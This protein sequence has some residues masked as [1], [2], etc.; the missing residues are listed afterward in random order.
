MAG[1]LLR[2]V[3]SAYEVGLGFGVLFLPYDVATVRSHV[4]V[5]V[6]LMLFAWAVWHLATARHER[7]W[8]RIADNGPGLAG[9]TFFVVVLYWGVLEL[10]VAVVALGLV[11]VA[12]EGYLAR[13]AGK[14]IAERYPPRRAAEETIGEQSP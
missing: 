6:P 12:V 10:D 11:A 1:Q 5:F 2:L 3:G 4:S 8:R 7:L 13:R 9:V 14:I